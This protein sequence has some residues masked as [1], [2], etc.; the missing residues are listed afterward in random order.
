MHRRARTFAGLLA[1]L[2]TAFSFTE[3]VL[4]STCAPMTDG[5]MTEMPGMPGSGGSGMPDM[6][7][8]MADEAP[9]DPASDCRIA[10]HSG[11]DPEAPGDQRH[12]PFAGV[13]SQGC[14]AVASLPAGSSETM[15]PSPEGAPDAA[16]GDARPDLLLSRALF[17]PPRA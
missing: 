3:T 13:M 10:S 2:A 5:P 14:S 15:A 12:C 4:A 11:G 16:P 1:L 6:A 9:A 7:M 17:H 8:G